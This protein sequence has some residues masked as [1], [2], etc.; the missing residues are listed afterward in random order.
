MQEN[1]QTIITLETAAKL[2]KFRFIGIL[3]KIR[4]LYKKKHDFTT[5]FIWQRNSEEKKHI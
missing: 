3:Y 4:R 5:Q 1:T 2:K